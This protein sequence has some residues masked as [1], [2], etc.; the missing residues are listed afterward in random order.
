MNTDP[1]PTPVHYAITLLRH[2][3]S[4]GNAEGY[5]Q[6]QFDFEL[7]ENG[8]KQVQALTKRWVN[9]NV[10]F[11]RVI[12]SPLMRA[13]QTAEIIS[14]GLIIPL[15]FDPLWMERD[16][17]YLAGVSHTEAQQ[18]F[19]RPDFFN[20]Y[21]PFGETGEGQWELYLRAGQAV[22]SLIRRSPGSYL[23]V[24]HGGLL[25][26]VMYTIL[27]IFPQANFHG[28]HFDFRN[29]SFAVVDYFPDT[30]VW[31]IERFNDNLHWREESP[32]P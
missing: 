2:G 27:G 1:S 22:L 25:N 3:E 11:D 29:T 28:A 18:R 31:M 13:R 32:D 12:A 14:A 4:V 10:Y 16:N 21:Q 17:G 8:K 23:V 24:S 7:T 20:I 19:P 30:H 9:E 15:E 6:G 26:M 5:H